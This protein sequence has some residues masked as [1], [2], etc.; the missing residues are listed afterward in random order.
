[1]CLSFLPDA[2]KN[3][4]ANVNYNFISEIRLRKGQPVL[5]EY[6]GK[7]CYINEFGISENYKNA[8][9]CGD[10][11]P[12]LMSAA[13]GCIYNYTEQIKNGFITVLNAVRIGIAGEYVIQNGQVQTIKNITSL[14]IRI[15]HN[16]VGCS[17]FIFENLFFNGLHST[18]LYSLPG[19]GKTTMLRDLTINL[20]KLKKYNILVFDERNEIAAIDGG[21]SGYDLGERVDV[22]RCYNKICAIKSAIRS[23]K[24]EI[25]V[26]DELYGNSDFEAVK[27]ASDCGICVI[28]SSHITDTAALK[29][30]PFEFFVNLTGINA[31]PL[32]YDKDFNTYSNRNTDDVVGNIYVGSQKKENADI[33]GTL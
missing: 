26:T 27:Y 22:I 12:V 5:I 33:C 11:E 13:N 3:S 24:P 8:I 18:L 2:V 32:I 6:R 23:M 19:L 9:V 31:C 17:N 29:N 15:P 28:A 10:L 14:N 20:S 21:G 16:V 30:L 25:I 4:L 7:Y 1:M